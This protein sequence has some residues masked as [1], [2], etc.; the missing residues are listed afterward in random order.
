MPA[1]GR[2]GG[3][4]RGAE[5]E[6]ARFRARACPSCVMYVAVGRELLDPV[7]AR[8]HDVDVARGVDGEPAD[9]PE[10]AV[11]AAERAPLGLERARAGLNFW[12]A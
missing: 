10:L 2:L 4:L 12:T 5:A 3:V 9:R 8:V 6:L 1:A 7:V 11:A